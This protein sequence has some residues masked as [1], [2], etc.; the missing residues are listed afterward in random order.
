MRE[1][2]TLIV[3]RESDATSKNQSSTHRNLRIKLAHI[4]NELKKMKFQ[5]KEPEKIFKIS[6]GSEL[7]QMENKKV[8]QTFRQYQ[9]LKRKFQKFLDRYQM[10]QILY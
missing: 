1:S 4:Q 9:K 8:K 10:M 3:N 2:P 5:N 7:S 6:I